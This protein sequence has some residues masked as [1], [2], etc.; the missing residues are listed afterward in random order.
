MSVETPNEFAVCFAGSVS[1]GIAMSPPQTPQAKLSKMLCF[2][3]VV[4]LLK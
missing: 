4:I 2:F 3:I 1:A